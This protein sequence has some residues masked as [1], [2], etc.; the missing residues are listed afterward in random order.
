MYGPVVPCD[1]LFL[2]RTIRPRLTLLAPAGQKAR[3]FEQRSLLF[4]KFDFID[5]RV[6]RFCIIHTATESSQVEFLE[7]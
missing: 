2:D 7:A 3:R 5:L 4:I 1:L 6:D